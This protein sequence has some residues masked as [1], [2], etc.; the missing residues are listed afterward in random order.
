MK[1]VDKYIFLFFGIAF[2]ILG[3]VWYELRGPR[4]FESTSH[5]YWINFVITPLA[6][7]AI[8][9]LIMTWRAVP[10]AAWGSAALLIAIPGMFGEAVSL[11]RFAAFMPRMRP[12]S[13]GRYGAF[14]FATY[15]V[16]L[17]IAEVMSLRSAR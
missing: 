3:T 13:A 17:T 6:T 11:S 7:T 2:W 5:R 16:F 14:L 4:V 15:A 8:C 9:I 10:A 1:P 12:E